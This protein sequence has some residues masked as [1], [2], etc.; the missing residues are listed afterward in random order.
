MLFDSL[1]ARLT[2][3]VHR[4]GSTWCAACHSLSDAW[5]ETRV[6]RLSISISVWPPV[7]MKIPLEVVERV[8]EVGPAAGTTWHRHAGVSF[9]IGNGYPVNMLN[10]SH[11]LVA[12]GMINKVQIQL[13]LLC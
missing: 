10:K 7:L 3:S 9:S 1:S 8:F 12:R 6:T 5:L 4:N 13:T 11:Y 2:A